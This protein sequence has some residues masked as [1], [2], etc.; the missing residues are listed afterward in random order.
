MMLFLVTS[1][2]DALTLRSIRDRRSNSKCITI[3]RVAI[4]G[5]LV[6]GRTG[7]D[8]RVVD[9]PLQPRRTEAQLPASSYSRIYCLNSSAIST[10]SIVCRQLT[11][12]ASR[13]RLERVSPPMLRMN[14]LLNSS[15]RDSIL[16]QALKRAPQLD[17]KSVV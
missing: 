11:C 13:I 2:S 6:T 8:V 9:R 16:P 5:Q 1:E 17:R 14:S 3:S 12:S 4:Q 7:T 10:S 15:Q